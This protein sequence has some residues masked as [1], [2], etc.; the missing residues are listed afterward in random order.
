MF[1]QEEE[2]T[3]KSDSEADKRVSDKSEDLSTG[4]D[5]SVKKLGVDHFNNDESDPKK[6]K[7]MSESQF[8][9]FHTEIE[10][11]ASRIV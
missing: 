3:A 9:P 11:G 2:E 7:A 10:F 4:A 5:V 8:L 6:S 1:L